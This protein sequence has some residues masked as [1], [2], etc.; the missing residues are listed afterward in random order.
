MKKAHYAALKTILILALTIAIFISLFSKVNIFKVAKTMGRINFGI[1]GL[2]LVISMIS[3]IIINSDRLRRILGTLGCKISFKESI[4]IKMGSLSLKALPLSQLSQLVQPVYLKRVHAFAFL[5]GTSS[6]FLGWI[7]N[8]FALVAF[9]LIGSN[10]VPLQNLR[11]PNPGYIY[12]IPLIPVCLFLIFLKSRQIQEAL[13]KISGRLSPVVSASLADF[14]YMCNN[15]EYMKLFYLWGYSVIFMF[16]KLVI[17]YILSKSLN[18]N[19]PFSAILYFLPPA[20]LFSSLPVTVLGLGIIEST[21]L[22]F[23]STYAS[24]ERILSLGLL[25][26]FTEKIFPMFVGL[27]FLRPFWN[28]LTRLENRVD[29][30]KS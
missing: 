5:R 22:L 28:K 25:I 11:L 7:L 16:S 17:F 14:I 9:M 13:I 10:S 18:L 29:V 4:F 27:F 20:I 3:N 24:Q 12:S 21:V 26:S 23:F 15:F 2:A 1:F 6:L 19:I 30:I 8:L